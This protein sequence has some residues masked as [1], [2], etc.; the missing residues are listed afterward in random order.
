M[1][2]KIKALATAISIKEARFMEAKKSKLSTLA[3]IYLHELD[4]L[5]E[6]FQIVAGE[7]YTD[8][9]IRLVEAE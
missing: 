9:F 4:G 1:N 2:E 7:T 5:K 8:Y 3:N 6:A